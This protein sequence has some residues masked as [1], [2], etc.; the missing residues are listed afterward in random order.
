[1]QMELQRFNMY[2]SWLSNTISQPLP[3]I[4]DIN[5]IQDYRGEN[6]FALLIKKIKPVVEKVILWVKD[7]ILKPQFIAGNFSALSPP[8]LSHSFSPPYPH[9]LLET[10]YLHEVAVT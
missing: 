6:Y 9:H 5:Y 1:M 10:D 8:K 4:A 2:K 3:I 7:I